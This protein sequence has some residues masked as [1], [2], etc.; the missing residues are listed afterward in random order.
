MTDDP[1]LAHRVASV[2]LLDPLVPEDALDVDTEGGT[3]FLRG[4]VESQELIEDLTRS[5]A[6][7]TGVREVVSLL[8]VPGTPTPHHD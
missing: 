5:A 8:H 1:R 6:R 3:I 2:L 4:V 7:I